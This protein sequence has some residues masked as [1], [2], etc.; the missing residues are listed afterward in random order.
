MI[1]LPRIRPNKFTSKPLIFVVEGR[2][3]AGHY[4]ENGWFYNDKC[5]YDGLFNAPGPRASRVSG[6]VSSRD[7]KK[8]P[9]VTE[10]YYLNND[11]EN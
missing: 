4:H 5:D 8:L 6:I 7:P 3:Y 9:Q 11:K 10:W 2:V 1:E